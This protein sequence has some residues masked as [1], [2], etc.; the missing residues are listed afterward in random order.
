M[1]WN[2]RNFFVGLLDLIIGVLSFFLGFRIVFKLFGA[3][4]NTPFVS[5]IYRLSEN[6]VYPFSG[7][8][9]NLSLGTSGAF[10]TVA[11]IALAAYIILG[12]ILISLV[13][14]VTATVIRK[15]HYEQ[16]QPLTQ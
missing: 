16:Q 14:S 15:K 10:D 7:M 2:L 8:F 3:N 11:V 6:L 9:P 13:D 5:W 4:P 12:Y 1:A